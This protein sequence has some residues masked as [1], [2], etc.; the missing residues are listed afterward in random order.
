MCNINMLDLTRY[1]MLFEGGQGGHMAH[2][3][4]Y[5]DFTGN[6]LIDL[7]ESLFGGKIENMKEKLD[8]T[9]INATM[10]MKG[11]VVFIRN[12]KDLNS[13][14]G[15]MS[16]EDMANKWA[17]N[18]A[19]AKNF[20]TAGKTIQQIFT[21]LGV[22]YFNPDS[23]TKKT[24]N[25]ECISAGKTNVMIYA[26]D[27]VAFHGYKIFKRG[28][29]EWEEIEDHEGDVDDIYKAAE[30]IDSAKPRPNLIIKYAEQA[31]KYK[32]QFIKAIQD[33]FKNEN[34]GLNISVE[35]WKRKRFN[36]I[37]PEWLDK[38]VDAIFNRWFNKDK[39]FKATE[40]KKLYPEHY[41][42]VKDD[43]FCKPFISK[44]MS[45]LDDLF[46]Q[47]GNAFINICDG[48]TNDGS[49]DKVIL[50]LKHDLD[51]VI[52]NV[53]KEGSTEHQELLQRQLDRLKKLGDDSINAAEGV[54]LMYKGRRMKLTGSFAPLN[55][56]LGIIKFN[57]K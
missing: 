36:D 8:G 40:L 53:K 41:N 54:V 5:T 55:S 33:L 22:K 37:K 39:S 45:P 50:T 57:K 15:G 25:C 14:N 23:E 7:I 28:S 17:E 46:L 13:E 43:K 16:I 1:V 27:R 35:E 44:V 52:D 49:K 10:N 32:E 47:I 26:T 12:K 34:L 2:P 11:E 20:V 3:F 48:F 29:S 9:N 21:K 4:D 31:I 24:I 30:G 51:E 42:D 18:P 19:V 56:I 38:E 6:D